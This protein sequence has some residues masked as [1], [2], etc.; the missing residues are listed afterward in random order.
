M[1]QCHTWHQNASLQRSWLF[2][3]LGEAGLEKLFFPRDSTYCCTSTY[4]L[5]LGQYESF[6]I[7]QYLYMGIYSFHCE[8]RNQF[9][10]FHLPAPVFIFKLFKVGHLHVILFCLSVMSPP[11]PK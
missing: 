1:L 10:I 11:T 3:T 9:D 2:M 8:R 5:I 7:S 4:S 6:L